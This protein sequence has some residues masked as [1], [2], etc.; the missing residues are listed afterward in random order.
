[1]G[2]VGWSM[3]VN[4]ANAYDNGKKPLSKWTK[5][6]ILELC[7]DKKE[8]AER[9]TAPELKKTLLYCSE[10]HHTSSYYNRTDFYD[11][12]ADALESLTPETVE[13]IIAARKPLERKPKAERKTF[14]AEISYTYWTGTRNHPKPHDV[15]ETV[16]YTDGD[17]MITTAHGNKRFSSITVLKIINSK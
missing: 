9:L 6:E 2:Y 5:A 13:Q 4:A 14:T 11:F 10:W 8:L 12:D 1:M 17:K 3:S 7:G 15:T 16:T